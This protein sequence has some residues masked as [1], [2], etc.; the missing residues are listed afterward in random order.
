MYVYTGYG[1]GGCGMYGDLRM[2]LESIPLK[3][4]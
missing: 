3:S 4:P 1:L 2:G